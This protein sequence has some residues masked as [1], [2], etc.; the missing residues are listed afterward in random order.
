LKAN[1]CNGGF[2]AGWKGRDGRLFVPTTRGVAFVDPNHVARK[3]APLPVWNEQV[4]LD[5][6]PA[7]ALPGLV[8]PPGRHS[9]EIRYTAL[10]FIAPGKL[11]FR[12][13]L[14]GFSDE[15]VE[16]G[17][18]RVA[19]YTSL[20]PGA[21]AFEVM[22]NN[23]DGYWIPVRNPLHLTVQA[24]FVQTWWFYAA[25][26]AGL[27]IAVSAGYRMRMRI[28]KAR[29]RQLEM[30]VDEQ[31]AQLRVAN[32]QLTAAKEAA[33]QVAEL[34]V[35]LS[36]HKQLILNSAG[37]GIFGLNADGVATFVNPSAAR[38]LGWSVDELVGRELHRIIHS[39]AG[40]VPLRHTECIVCSATLASAR[41]GLA[42]AF[43][44]RGGNS[45]PV[46]Y[47]AATIVGEDSGTSGVVV[48]FRD[49]SERLAIERMKGEFVST[50]SH[51]LRTP[52][53]SIRGALGLLGSGLLG[54]VAAKGQRM[55]EIAVVNTDRLVRLI[56]DILDLE[57][58]DSG[59]LELIRRSVS[60]NELMAEA[61]DGVQSMAEQAGVTLA[62]QPVEALLSVDRDRIVQVLTNLLSNAIKFSP[63]GTT[64]TLGG[65]VKDETLTFHVS[66]HGR[67][68]P[69][70][71]LSSIFER[72]SQ[73]DASDARDK[74]GSGLGLAI[75]RSIVNAHGGRIWVE[76]ESGKGSVFQFTIPL[77]DCDR[78]RPALD[79]PRSLLVCEEDASAIVVLI[80]EDDL[81]L[82]RVMAA[83]LHMRGLR[84]LHATS[85]QE[86]LTLCREQA[87]SLIVLDLVLPDIDGF[88]VVDVLRRDTALGRVPLLVHSALELVAADQMRLKLGP[89]G[90]LTK[91]RGNLQDFESQVAHLLKTVTAPKKEGQHAA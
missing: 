9:L 68:V 90:F 10:S 55:L 11:T 35:H 59:K 25:C 58:I 7:V 85:G 46:E 44:H 57:R 42:A 16:A 29:E 34:N 28:L 74:G 84:T 73:V 60:P 52:L 31:T 64:V 56:N 86:A 89:T 83:S 30:R 20:P 65:T 21:Y 78:V 8:V 6:K 48:T 32:A 76:S 41:V 63:P 50:V 3:A 36:R 4:L 39:E 61:S 12:Y 54:N 70:E 37:E 2:P 15:W 62:I 67:G 24:A 53:T 75:C 77:R 1:E 27:L 19:F 82:A 43:R 45:I 66:D 91:S 18:R 72:F 51:E 23:D 71:K 22:A 14:Q 88:A 26:A 49:V 47:T 17:N 5:G 79:V 81:D 38:M 33:E 87:P 80:V 40:Q 69:A 13:R